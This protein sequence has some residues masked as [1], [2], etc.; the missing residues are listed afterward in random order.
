M[1]TNSDKTGYSLTSDFRI[2][3]NTALNNFTFLMVD[4][5]GNAA[6]GLTIVAQRSLDGAALATMANSASEISNGLYKINLATADTNAD[7]IA[8]RFSATGAKDRIIAFPT[9]TE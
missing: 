9:Q 2:K 8:Y 5:S 4:S 6:T 1:T 3:K 7:F